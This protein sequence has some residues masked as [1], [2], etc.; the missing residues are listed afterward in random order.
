MGRT[1]T[2]NVTAK[3]IDRAKLLLEVI[4]NL[5]FE[6]CPVALA[7][8]AVVPRCK[9]VGTTKIQ[10]GRTKICLPIR[11]QQFI[12]AFDAKGVVKP[13]KFKVTIP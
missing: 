3:R 10:V 13:F 11:A 5:P 9:G 4:W 6:C 7:A 2:I 8:R 1:I 12:E